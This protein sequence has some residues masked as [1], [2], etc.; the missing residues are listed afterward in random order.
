MTKAQFKTL[1]QSALFFCS[2]VASNA[3][4]ST[5]RFAEAAPFR[6]AEILLQDVIDQV[7][8]FNYPGVNTSDI[9]DLL[10][11]YR[12]QLRNLGDTLLRDEKLTDKH[13]SELSFLC[14][15]GLL[16]MKEIVMREG[17]KLLFPKKP[18]DTPDSLKKAHAGA[19]SFFWEESATLAVIANILKCEK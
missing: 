14:S 9:P 3:D 5:D 19:L 8:K 6:A 16:N 7:S 12:E 18:G 17:R 2:C 1:L 11:P 15:P 4:C 13:L 10:L